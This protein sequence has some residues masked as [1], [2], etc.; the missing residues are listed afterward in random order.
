MPAT[1]FVWS[2]APEPHR[3]R[4]QAILRAHPELRA[5]IGRNPWTAVLIAAAVIV[6]LLL[7]AA[8]Q[9][10]PWWVVV[11]VAW[12]AGAFL[13]HA[14]FVMVHECAHGMVFARRASNMLAA[15]VANLP[16]FFPSAI[17]FRT[18]HLKHH[19]FQGVPELDA[20]LPSRWEA[21]LIRHFFVG[22]A[23]WLLAFPLFQI[24]RTIRLREIRLVEPWVAFNWVVQL[25]FNVAIWWLLGPKA[26]AY[27]ALSLCF[28]VGLHPLGARWIQEHYLTF[29]LQETTSYYGPLNAVALN[30]GYH[31][32]HHDLPSVPWHRL[33]AVR[34][35]APEFYDT[36][37][38]HHSWGLLLLRFLFDREL[39]LYSRIIRRNRGDV[40]LSDESRPDAE[41]ATQPLHRADAVA[42]A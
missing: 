19:S 32:E 15:I 27:F 41:M 12:S 22:K 18:Y 21:H 10:Q 7:A 37:R 23:L 42:S 17:S 5:L 24:A 31:N 29:G 1:D 3:A 8:V 33:P 20:D 36:L 28:S 2:D 14:L 40:P 25:A 11:A 9:A 39:S 6:Q 35:G 4:T 16:Q 34:R 30:V 38:A 26:L 13:D